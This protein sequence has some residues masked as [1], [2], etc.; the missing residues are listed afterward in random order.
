M[1][2]I[3]ISDG[4]NLMNRNDIKW[5]D[6][7]G[8]VNTIIVRNKSEFNKFYNFM[9]DLGLQGLFHND[10]TFEAWQHLAKINGCVSDYIIFEYQPSKGMTFGYSI[11]ESKNWYDKEPLDVSV[12]DSFYSNSKL[13][14]Q[15]NNLKKD[16][17]IQL[18]K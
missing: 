5:L 7:F 4:D 8:G 14:N 16:L 17:D 2:W 6:F 12:L 11:E 15:N 13:F 3:L 18:E 1:I 9:S 10:K